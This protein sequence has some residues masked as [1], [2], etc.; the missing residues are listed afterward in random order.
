MTDE[1]RALFE[2]WA[3]SQELPTTLSLN[4]S[5]TF[6]SSTAEAAWRA[7]QAARIAAPPERSIPARYDYGYDDGLKPCS[8]GKF[9]LWADYE[10]LATENAALRKDA[11]RLDW[12]EANPAIE[13][14][15]ESDDG[16]LMR[17]VYVVTGYPNDREWK[18]VGSAS[19]LR[20]AI[21]AAM[22]A[23]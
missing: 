17:N 2:Q 18:K 4:P 7:W 5:Y 12:M 8:L 14:G 22:E 3:R 13:I 21:D 9:C 16:E 1:S 15:M 11:E 23:K 10:K 20:A 19:S 6:A